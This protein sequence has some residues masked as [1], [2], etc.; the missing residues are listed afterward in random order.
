MS[1]AQ[2]A[3]VF[4]HDDVHI[5]F[6]IEELKGAGEYSGLYSG[7]RQRVETLECQVR[8][9]TTNM[10]SQKSLETRECARTLLFARQKVGV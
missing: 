10:C 3:D 6:N 9:L 1:K 7:I 5:A 2:P 4:N 8:G